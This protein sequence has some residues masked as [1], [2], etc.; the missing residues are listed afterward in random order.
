[1]HWVYW[2]AC[3]RIADINQ[4]KVIK[5][6]ADNVENRFAKCLEVLDKIDNEKLKIVAF[7][8]SVAELCNYPDV[9]ERPPKTKTQSDHF[10]EAAC[11]VGAHD[12]EVRFNAKMWAS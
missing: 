10:K 2:D 7:A 8:L 9:Q 4:E 3:T 12:D 5:L 1:M 6:T 11:E